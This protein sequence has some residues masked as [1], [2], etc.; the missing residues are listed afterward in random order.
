MESESIMV[1]GVLYHHEIPLRPDGTFC[2]TF[3][4]PYTSRF[5]LRILKL[6]LSIFLS[7]GD[8][9]TIEAD[10]KDLWKSVK[11]SGAHAVEDDYLAAFSAL[12]GT[13]DYAMHGLDEASF[14]KKNDEIAKIDD[15]LFHKFKFDSPE[16]VSLQTN[17]LRY[18]KQAF[19]QKNIKIRISY[20]SAFL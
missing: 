9:L 16:F 14:V 6:P 5:E 15:D 10:A 17:E 11:F 12:N 8:A 3:D 18:R 20:S 13:I 2:E 1:L 4:I 7:D 19:L